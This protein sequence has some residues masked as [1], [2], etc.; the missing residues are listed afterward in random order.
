M[1]SRLSLVCASPW[2]G[3]VGAT[4]DLVGVP[5]LQ[6]V[7]PKL[8]LTRRCL[9]VAARAAGAWPLGRSGWRWFSTDEAYHQC[10]C[11]GPVLVAVARRFGDP[12]VA[13][14]AYR[15]H[16]AGSDR[17]TWSVVWKVQEA[18][19]EMTRAAGEPD[20]N[21]RLG[22]DPGGVA[23]LFQELAEERIRG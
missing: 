8:R 14:A 19:L 3:V 10:L 15:A 18:L 16:R 2:S 11:P 7:K 9:L 13:V 23:M 22:E 17:T 5:H 1:G 4:V 6:E 21:T 20:L 12:A